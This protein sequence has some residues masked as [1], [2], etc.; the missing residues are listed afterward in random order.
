MVA[1][2]KRLVKGTPL[3]F[4]EMDTNLDNI[5][6]ELESKVTLSQSS[7]SIINAVQNLRDGVD[8][9]G[10]TLLKLFNLII[11]LQNNKVNLNDIIN[12]VSH[13]DI[14]KPLSAYQGY[15]LKNSINQEITNRSISYNAL[16]SKINNEVIN[17]DNAITQAILNLES[18]LYSI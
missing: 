10:D 15:L 3:S 4:E 12:D 6:N 5:N 11:N 16:D 2:V 18:K 17:R 8:V 13:F 14:N 1:L 9:S 7:L